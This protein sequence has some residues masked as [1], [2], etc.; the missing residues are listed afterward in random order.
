MLDYTDSNPKFLNIVTT[1]DDAWVYR[2]NPE[3]KAL[4]SQWEHS[5]S[6]KPK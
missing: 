6:P 2:Y 3:T 1:D 5:T 4:S